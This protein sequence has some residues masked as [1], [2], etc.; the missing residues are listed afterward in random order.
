MDKEKCSP[1]FD[2]ETIKSIWDN[3]KIFEQS[4]INE[5]DN[6]QFI[7][8]DGPPFATGL[9]HYGHIL[10]GFIK[11]SICRYQTQ[12]SRSVPRC[13]GWD[14][15][16]L[17]IE[18]EIEKE[19]KIKT[20]QDILSWGIPNYNSACRQIVM[21]YASE[22]ETIMGRLGRWVDFKNDY[23][24][25]DFDF[26]NSV[27][28]VFKQLGIKGLI[29]P[30]YK[31]MP[32]SVACT[33]SLSNFETQQ[34]YQEIE[35]ITLYVN[36]KLKDFK[37]KDFKLK[38]FKL[39]DFKLN[40]FKPDE[41]YLIVWTTTP[42]TLPSNLA[43]AVNPTIKYSLVEFEHIYYIVAHNL[44]GK[45]FGK[46]TFNIIH[47][48][49]NG[50]D[51]IGLKYYPLFNSYPIDKLKTNTKAHTVIGAGFV[52]DT[53]GTGLVHIAPSYGE[54]DYITCI[55]ECL[56]DK[57]ETLFMSIDSEGYF[58]KNICELEDLGGVFYK[59]HSINKQDRTI[60]DGNSMIINRLKVAGK[61]FRQDR[62]KHSYPFCWRSDTP[63]MYRATKS[64]FVNVEVLKDRMV[65]LN[66]QINWIPGHIGSGRF[67]NWL[68]S[69][70]DWCIARSRYWG[71]PIPIWQN[72]NDE[73]DYIIIESAQELEL[74]CGL[75]INTI[76][77]LHRDKIDHLTINKDGIIYKR[78]EDVFDCWFESG[79][80]PYASI[81]YPYKNSDIK[82]PAD[83]IAEG[84]DQT[85]GWFYTLIVISTALFNDLPFRNVI[86]NGLILASDGKKMSKRL[87]NYPDPMD[88]VRRY[89]S[90][91]LRLYLLGS[92]AT[93]GESLKF[94]E[95]GVHSMMRDIIIP[96]KSALSMYLRY[97][98]KYLLENPNDKLYNIDNYSTDNI[99][100]MYAIKY[101][102]SLIK[103]INYELS[104]YSLSDA[105]NKLGIIVEILNNTY[106]KYN[107]HALKGKN[108]YWK[109]S[110]STLGI[111]L[112][113]LSISIAPIAPFFAEYLYH[114]LNRQATIS[115]V[116]LTKFNSIE[117]NLPSLNSEQIILAD[118]M[119]H[120]INIIKQVLSIRSKNN[121]SM[122][123][124]IG[125]L[126]VKTSDILLDFINL[127]S[128]F[129]ID[130]LNI[131]SINVEKFDWANIEINLKPN[132]P[133]IKQSYSNIEQ[134]KKLSQLI[135]LISK[136]IP[137]KRLLVQSNDINFDGLIIKQS[138][139]DIIIKPEA[140]INYLSEYA[141]IDGHNY[142]VYVDQIVSNEI[143]ILAYGKK[144]GRQFQ[145]M[146]QNAGLESWNPIKLGIYGE[147]EFDF[148]SISP[149]IEKTCEIKPNKLF[150]RIVN[151]VY[152]Q[153]II[154]NDGVILFLY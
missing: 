135:T 55:A 78:I 114:N 91:A 31:V 47:E 106:I 129:I 102:G 39:N 145:L 93:K 147:T 24:T 69:A 110:I 64:W 3:D 20:K 109:S 65:E 108:P 68:A 111:L 146:R 149:I 53:D 82:F 1:V 17:P 25:L 5:A 27:W 44:V 32:Y 71:T 90:D 56:V 75:N 132:Y 122:N 34:N 45:V 151:P 143:K 138:M 150:T 136:D 49:I 128:N 42:W 126:I 107:R 72:I 8:Y 144:L 117:Y 62:Y 26:M 30:S 112:R 21:K 101:I 12:N 131:L 10:A 98:Y 18:F 139:V 73:S 121:I 29:Y 115:S 141:F 13:A 96:L 120:I 59:N 113:Y 41:V 6:E 89:G 28:W 119:R 43:I 35:D 100:D 16:G 130:E 80:M 76:K 85:R 86:V 116:H 148:E 104:R 137:L 48:L 79:S 70:K 4:I 74:L 127:Y 67:N 61:I 124:P 63:L 37:L 57:S 40:D 36:F 140:K 123:T 142:C 22:W 88:V 152:E 118:N 58:I 84:I 23:K 133:M 11:D 81:G 52:S 46:K 50:T 94:N 54:D 97:E 153:N 2:E 19:H 60:I 38:D 95:L 105:V 154:D 87:K 15:H 33:T 66:K 125:H 92:N 77:D 9:P 83:F 7:I 134:I 99:L 103:S 51:L 14:C